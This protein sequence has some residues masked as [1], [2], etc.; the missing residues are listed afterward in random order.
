MRNA[1]EEMKNGLRGVCCR[2]AFLIFHFNFSFL[3]SHFSFGIIYHFSFGI[4]SHFSFGI[5]SHFSFLIWRETAF[6]YAN[7]NVIRVE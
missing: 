7:N 4:T 1:N 2:M 6:L 3:T 5:T